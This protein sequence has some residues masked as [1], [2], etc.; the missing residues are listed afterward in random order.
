MN[1]QEC[2]NHVPYDRG[3]DTANFILVVR[4]CKVCG[5]FIAAQAKNKNDNPE[6]ARN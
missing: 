4:R 3:H 1:T 5:E 2:Q 6:R